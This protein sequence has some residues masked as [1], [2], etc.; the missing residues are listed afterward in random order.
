M[1]VY[2]LHGRPLQNIT[3]FLMNQNQQFEDVMGGLTYAKESLDPARYEI[4]TSL[5]FS[6]CVPCYRLRNH[7]LLTSLDVLTTGTYQRL[8]SAIKVLPLVCLNIGTLMS[9][10][11]NLSFPLH[12]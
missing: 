11:R 4:C 1:E 12:L 2:I 3:A 7:D 9:F 6:L 5:R 10:H 8:P